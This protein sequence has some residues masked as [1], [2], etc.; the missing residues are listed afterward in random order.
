NLGDPAGALESYRQ[1]AALFEQLV[2]AEP[3][4]ALSQRD[5]AVAYH[6]LGLIT[7]QLGAEPKQAEDERRRHWMQARGH[8]QRAQEIIQALQ[9][10]GAL[11]DADAGVPDLLAAEIARCEAMIARL[12]RPLPV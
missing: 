12:G 2:R 8:Q 6:R 4:R 3:S 9:Q 5:L 7:A 1:S 11:A 10:R